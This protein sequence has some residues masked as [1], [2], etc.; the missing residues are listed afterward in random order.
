MQD[1]ENWIA[2]KLRPLWLTAGACRAHIA[3]NCVGLSRSLIDYK[4]HVMDAKVCPPAIHWHCRWCSSH[5]S[6][7]IAKYVVQYLIQYS[8]EICSPLCC[9]LM[10][11]Q[12]TRWDGQIETHC[13]YQFKCSLPVNQK[14]ISQKYIYFVTLASL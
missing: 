4:S 11:V 3:N 9:D 5:T 12:Y 8:Y 1:I 6:L 13:V 7:G 10:Q 14:T 2:Q